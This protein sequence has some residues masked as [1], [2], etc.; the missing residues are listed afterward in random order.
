MK[1]PVLCSLMLAGLLI[2]LA[3]APDRPTPLDAINQAPPTD[4]PTPPPTVPQALAP[5]LTPRPSPRPF[6]ALATAVLPSATPW[7]Y[8]GDF[9]LYSYLPAAYN[10]ETFTLA[11][12]TTQNLEALKGSVV[13]VQTFASTCKTCYEQTQNLAQTYDRLIETGNLEPVTF[14]ILSISGRDTPENMAAYQAEYGRDD[15]DHWLTGVAT[16]TLARSLG[17]TFG[18]D[19]V[20]PQKGGLFFVDKYGF[21]H[22]A[23]PGLMSVDRLVDT[24]IHFIGGLGIDIPLPGTPAPPDATAPS[25]LEASVTPDLEATATETPTLEG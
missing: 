4:S 21:A 15:P 3:C 7:V 18:A 14:V 2:G 25:P 11:D 6:P 20:N 17:E 5:T 1:R 9:I 12:E 16:L 24:V 22:T 10:I 13:V 8:R 23:A 19:F